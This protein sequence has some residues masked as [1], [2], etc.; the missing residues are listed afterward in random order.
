MDMR[1]GNPFA[2]DND[3][4]LLG[5]VTRLTAGADVLQLW[6]KT[7]RVWS[8]VGGDTA[9]SEELDNNKVYR[10]T[11][12]FDST[13]VRIRLYEVVSG[14]ADRFI[15]SKDAAH[16]VDVTSYSRVGIFGWTIGAVVPV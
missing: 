3:N 11:T 2:V 7:A 13:N 15:D 5:A 1:V 16:G 4:V 12:F 14:Q 6:K 8:Q 10:L 9:L